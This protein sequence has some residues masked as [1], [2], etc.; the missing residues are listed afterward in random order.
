MKK[1]N[2][3]IRETLVLALQNFQKNNFKMIKKLPSNLI[4]Q[5]A[6]GEVVDDPVSIVKELLE[7]SSE[8]IIEIS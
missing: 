5:I 3:S 8:I 7:K 1:K 2:L 4:N 6:A